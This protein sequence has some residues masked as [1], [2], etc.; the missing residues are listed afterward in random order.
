MDRQRRIGIFLQAAHRW[1]V[2]RLRADPGR[3]S[4]VRAL[5]QRWRRLE[6]CTRFLERDTW[7]MSAP[8]PAKA[9]RPLWGSGKVAEPHLLVN[10][11]A[12]L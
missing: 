2:S 11:Q 5:L 6:G 4:E 8:R 10:L 7:L 3:M 1:A 9:V 12:C